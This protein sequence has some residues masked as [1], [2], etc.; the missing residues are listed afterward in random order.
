MNEKNTVSTISHDSRGRT[1]C[2]QKAVTEE[3]LKLY[4]EQL[5]DS[6]LKI[7]YTRTHS[8]DNSD[9]DRV[10]DSDSSWDGVRYCEIEPM[11]N[12]RHLVVRGN[13]VIGIVF[14]IRTNSRKIDRYVFL[15]D[16]SVQEEIAMG[17]SASHS[18]DWT[19]I[20]SVYLVKRGLDGAPEE[21]SS[22]NFEQ[23]EMYPSF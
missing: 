14:F 19:Y 9:D 15:F 20:N 3:Q 22:V 11:K 21:G 8:Y 2:K 6:L 18:S 5:A 12:S 1:S 17:Y 7:E 10:S 23:S 16:G 4:A 13:S